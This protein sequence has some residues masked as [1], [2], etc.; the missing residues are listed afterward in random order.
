MDIES[1]YVILRSTKE[2]DV[3]AR[4]VGSGGFITYATPED[5]FLLVLRRSP[6]ITEWIP[7]SALI[8]AL[9]GDDG[10]ADD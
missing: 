5:G 10:Q 3:V 8:Q 7:R 9:G 4:Y 1:T 2:G 6:D